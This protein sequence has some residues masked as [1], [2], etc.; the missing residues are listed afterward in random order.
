M[1]QLLLVD[2]FEL[3]TWEELLALVDENGPEGLL[4]QA[5]STHHESPCHFSGRSYQ[6]GANV[7]SVL[8]VPLQSSRSSGSA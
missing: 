5:A 2:L 4:R 8:T 6:N 1:A 3:V 7:R